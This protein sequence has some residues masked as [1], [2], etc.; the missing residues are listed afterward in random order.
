LF[1]DNIGVGKF[2]CASWV[3]EVI[4]KVFGVIQGERA[5]QSS[6]LLMT[7]AW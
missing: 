4:V 6:G 2:T 1:D 3:G 7:L 5:L